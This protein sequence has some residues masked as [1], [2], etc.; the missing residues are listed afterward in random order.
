ME[1]AREKKRL[2]IILAAMKV[3]TEKG[4]DNTSMEDLARALG[5]T[6]SYFY[7]YFRSKEDLIVS[8]FQYLKDRALEELEERLRET[9]DP[10]RRLEIWIREHFRQVRDNPDFLRFVYSFVFSSMAK[11]MNIHSSL[12][13]KDRYFN[14]L[15]EIIR[16]GQRRGVFIAEDVGA[17]AYS[18]RGTIYG[19]MRYLFEEGKGESEI[20]EVESAVLNLIMGG[21]VNRRSG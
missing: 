9:D 5:T 18:I 17:L 21:V 4:I 11:R 7:F 6:K 16:D 10:V 12:V 20:D 19:A 1:S 8:I 3:F 14:L 15:N 13:R 2:E